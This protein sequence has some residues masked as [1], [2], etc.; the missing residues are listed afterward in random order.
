MA[1]I[2]VNGS[3]TAEFPIYCGLKQGDPLAP[4]LFILVMKR[5]H[6]SVSRAVDE[7]IFKGLHI[8]GT[9][10]LSHLFYAGDAMFIAPLKVLHEM[11]MLR[12]KFFNRG[13]DQGSKI[14]WV[15]WDKVLS[16]KKNGGLGFS[17]FYALNRVLILKWVWRFMSQKK[18]MWS[19][20]IRAIYG[21]SLDSHSRKFTSPWG[22]ILRELQV[23]KDKGF[24][25]L[26]HC[27][28]RIGNGASTRFW[29]DVWILDTPLSVRFPRLYALEN[30]IDASVAEKCHASSLDM[31]F[32]RPT[33]DGL[34][35]TQWDDLV[36]MI[37]TLSFSPDR[38]ICDLFG[39][40]EFFVKT[41]RS[42]IDDM[43]LPNSGSATRWVRNIPIKVNIPAWR[44]RLDRFPTRGNLI[45]RGLVMDSVMCPFA[46]SLTKTLNTNFLHV[47]RLN[48]FPRRYAVGGISLGRIL[49]RLQIGINGSTLS[50]CSLSLKICWMVSSI[51]RGGTYG[52]FGIELFSMFSSLSVL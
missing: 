1:S 45:V 19:L 6:L 4:F 50:F 28:I 40:G 17:S 42:T 9:L 21:S 41:I 52:G 49:C 12:N 13:D 10:N 39:D 26:S 30:D 7:G 44:I 48:I 35:K 22:S 43:F 24:D 8:Q 3:P 2:M 25:F 11:E 27:K 31:S 33:R 36:S 47:T 5:L 37:G 51:Q 14:T 16:S 18:S 15:A 20:V 32:R 46:T 23:L 29:F 38:W 34:E